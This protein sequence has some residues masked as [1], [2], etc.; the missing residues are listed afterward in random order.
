VGLFRAWIFILCLIGLDAALKWGT[1]LFVPPLAGWMYPFGGI[2]LI[3]NVGGISVSLNYVINTGAAWSLFQGYSGLLF[4]CRIAAI[5]AILWLQKREKWRLPWVLILSG[6]L[7]NVLDYILYRHVIDYVHVV[8]WGWS[9]PVFNLADALISIGALLLLLPQQK[10]SLPISTP[11]KEGVYK[12]AK[13]LKFQVLC[14]ATELKKLIDRLPGLTA[15]PLGVFCDGQ[16]IAWDTWLAEQQ[17]AIDALKGGQVPEDKGGAVCWTQ[18]R[19]ALWLHKID[20]KGFL[21]KIRTP[22]VQVQPHSLTYSPVDGVFRPMSFGPESIVWGL[23]FSYP[24]LYQDPVTNEV[25]A[26]PK[27]AVF[28]E[29]RKWVRE[30]TRATPFQVGEK[31]INV[32]IRV[33]KRVLP[34]IARHP[35]LV[36]QQIT[37]WESAHA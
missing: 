29:I 34:W 1:I 35:Q 16:A 36:R 3:E 28:E 22:V 27:S 13:W 17:R 30:T 32:P 24:Q 18:D 11:E 31:R 4:T 21:V 25:I 9:F 2:P 12:A 37:I 26:A 6:A 14:D 15:F 20:N 23:Q 5:A 10:T 8:F 33:G 7:G 19:A